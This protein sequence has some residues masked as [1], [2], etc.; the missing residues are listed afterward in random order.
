MP[1]Q[2]EARDEQREQER[3]GQEWLQIAVIEQEP[4]SQGREQPDQGGK[5]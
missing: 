5:P 4:C 2:M 1:T 3:S